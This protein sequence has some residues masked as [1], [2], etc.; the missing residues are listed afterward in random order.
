MLYCISRFQILFDFDPLFITYDILKAH[1]RT[2][3]N[4]VTV[5]RHF[6]MSTYIGQ[7]ENKVCIR[8]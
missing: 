2:T 6:K 3:V 4:H 5:V 8:K 7:E 1:I